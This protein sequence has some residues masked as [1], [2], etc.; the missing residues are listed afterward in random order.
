MP[1]GRKAFWFGVVLATLVGLLSFGVWQWRAAPNLAHPGEYG[2][3]NTEWQAIGEMNLVIP[4]D[5]I[6]PLQQRAVAG[7]NRAAN[8][9]ANHYSEL[10]QTAEEARWLTLAA[11]RGDCAS[12]ALLRGLA[13]RSDDRRGQSHWNDMLRRHACTWAKAYQGGAVSRPADLIPLWNESG[14]N[15]LGPAN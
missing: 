13:E 7:D 8:E 2:S 4:A 15:T 12:M 14:E 3:G 9:L 11:N 10:R 6:A 1:Q 5:E